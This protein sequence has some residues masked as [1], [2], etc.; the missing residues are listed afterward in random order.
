MAV[1]NPQKKTSPHR[2]IRLAALTVPATEKEILMWRRPCPTV[3]R[4]ISEWGLWITCMRLDSVE[5][6]IQTGTPAIYQNSPKPS[7][8]IIKSK[9]YYPL[10]III[11]FHYGAYIVIAV[12]DYATRPQ[13]HHVKMDTES[14]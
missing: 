4:T 12:T 14:I 8:P 2:E 10:K 5:L 9:V 1:R 13:L 6:K 3:R 7:K 11:I